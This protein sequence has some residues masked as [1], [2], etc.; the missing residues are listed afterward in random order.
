MA[1]DFLSAAGAG[2]PMERKFSHGADLCSSKRSR[3]NAKTIH[4]VMCLRDWL[5]R[6]EDSGA[7]VKEYVR[8][9][10]DKVLED[11]TEKQISEVTSR[12]K[13]N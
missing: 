3:L 4:E 9:V 6:R 5:K 8:S 13:I 10:A 2:V 7:V 1:R 11:T 12:F